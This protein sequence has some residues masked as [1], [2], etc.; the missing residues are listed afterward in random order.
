MLKNFFDKF[1]KTDSGI[2]EISSNSKDENITSENID[3]KDNINDI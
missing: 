1:K 2:D 3:E